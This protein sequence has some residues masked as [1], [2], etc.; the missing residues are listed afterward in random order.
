MVNYYGERVTKR[1]QDY[2]GFNFMKKRFSKLIWLEILILLL[3][4]IP[5]VECYL[6]AEY[7]DREK[8]VEMHQWLSDYI[9]CLMFM[10]IYFIIRAVF[11]YSIYSN[12]FSR[13]ICKNHD[14]YPGF[15]FIFK[16]A[17]S[18]MPELTVT[19]MFFVSTF[20]FAFILHVCEDNYIRYNDGEIMMMNE[21]FMTEVYVTLITLTTVGYGDYSPMNTVG[22]IVCCIIAL[23]G[24]FMLSLVVLIVSKAFE[25][26]KDQ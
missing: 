21:T 8:M 11:N 9:M 7:N 17:L 5:Y 20:I 1:V 3:C 13:N 16:S 6:E 22:K 4:P 24:A 25:L 19:L 15:R 2:H 18:S 10:R 23:F 26:E 14:F 12:S